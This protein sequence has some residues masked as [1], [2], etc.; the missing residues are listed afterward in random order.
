M[1]GKTDLGNIWK[2]LHILEDS[3]GIAYLIGNGHINELSLT[4]AMSI[5]IKT[6]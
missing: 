1:T 6:D 5:E 4:L 2:R 3:L